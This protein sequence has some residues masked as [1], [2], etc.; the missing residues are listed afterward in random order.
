MKNAYYHSFRIF[1]SLYD[2]YLKCSIIFYKKTF[3]S[4]LF[5]YFILKYVNL[6]K[7]LFYVL[8]MGGMYTY[9]YEESHYGSSHDYE[10]RLNH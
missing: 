5:N 10:I 8:L 1:L 6:M 4:T 3:F 2:G 9:K 7:K